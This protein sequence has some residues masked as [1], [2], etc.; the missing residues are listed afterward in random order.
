LP[1]R[2]SRWT[3]LRG[4]HID[5]KSREQFERRVYKRVVDIVDCTAETVGALM[6][7]RLSSSGVSVEIKVN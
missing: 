5:K 2:I 4:P 3:V 7:L 6:D 1:V